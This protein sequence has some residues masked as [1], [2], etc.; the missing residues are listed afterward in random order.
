MLKHIF[1]RLVTVSVAAATAL[2]P[3]ATAQSQSNQTPDPVR[4]PPVVVN[5]YNEPQ[6]VQTLPVSVTG[7]SETTLNNAGIVKLSD[8]E[9]LAPN[10]F[11]SEFSARKSTNARFRG[12]GSSPYNPGIITYLD[13]VPQLNAY[14]SN[15]EFMDIEQVEFVRAPQNAFFGRN[16]LGGMIGVTTRKPSMSEWKRSVTVPI[17][18]YSDWDAQLSASGPLADN[19]AVGLTLG[20]SQSKGFTVNDVTGRILDRRRLTYGKAHFWWTPTTEWEARLIVTGESARDGDN[21]LNDLNVVRRN[22]FRVERD[23]EGFMHRDILS[24]TL[25]T[26]R[27]G[28]VFSFSTITGV[29]RWKT[30]DATDLDYSLRPLFTRDDTEKDLQLTQEVR[31]ASGA[32]P[33]R[34]AD[35][36]TMR[37]QGGALFVSQNYDQDAATSYPPFLLLPQLAVPSKL[38]LPQSSLNDLGLG[39]YGQG[40]ATFGEN[41]DLTFGIRLDKE[42]RKANLATSYEPAVVPATTTNREATFT[43]KSPMIAASY[44]LQEG[45]MIFGSFGRGQ[46]PG[47]FNGGAP[48]GAEGYDPEQAWH[49]EGGLKTLLAD[50]RWS[51]NVTGFYIDWSN[52]QMVQPNPITPAQTY[53]TNVGAARTEGVEFDLNARPHQKVD[54]FTTMGITRG[55]FVASTTGGAN[56]AGRI[57]PYTPGFT[58]GGGS[59]VS[60]P[61]ASGLT[62][63]GRGEIKLNS[64]FE[65]N[66]TNSQRQTAYSLVNF[67]GGLRGEVAFGEFWMTNAFDKRY[68]PVAFAYNGFTSSGFLAEMGAPR[69]YGIRLGVTF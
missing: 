14:S 3:L 66:E 52:M 53:V 27:N 47:G 33:L 65:Y 9:M 11:F 51:V 10:T 68:I 35:S 12:I 1:S 28:D 46:K 39:L 24:S 58:M 59:Q 50:G 22:P 36:V 38:H 32:T 2:S 21:G 56:L 4:L 16:T 17:G 55:R 57:L 31:L 41:L 19:L 26:Q 25:Q 42:K 29:V 44:R 40:T 43:S 20:R 7:I 49:F 23:F 60:Q 13:G 48:I 67:R 34:L 61:L 54:V 6:D 45:R 15:V 30:H 8:A 37:W 18:N 62:L 69:R 5:V 64:G 63:F